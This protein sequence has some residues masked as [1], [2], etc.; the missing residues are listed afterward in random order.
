[1][2]VPRRSFGRMVLGLPHNAQDYPAVEVAARVAE[3]LNLQC[4]GAFIVEPAIITLGELPDARELK[5]V[6]AGWQPVEG[7]SLARDLEEAVDAARRQFAAVA[8][9]LNT[10]MAF[11]LALGATAEVV[12]SL[13]GADDIVAMIEPRHP[14]DRITRQFLS[15]ME[16][17]F[18]TSSAVM[19][20]PRRVLRKDGPIVA[21]AAGSDD[22]A[23]DVAADMA[24]AMHES[25]IVINTTE[26]PIATLPSA[27]EGRIKSRVISMPLLG[28]SIGEQ[29]LAALAGVRERMI[30]VC[31]TTL[32]CAQSRVMADRRGIPV[33]VTDDGG[34]R[35]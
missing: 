2:A 11:H 14:A 33:L 30:V 34:Q 4:L 16:A 28:P 7:N 35:T 19:L 9:R 10:D 22:A 21:I 23:I 8:V 26:E 20:F 31:R 17:A 27:F 24:M 12:A 32:D 25:L 3:S 13:A 18:Q 6:A 15:F 1:M 5:S 29:V